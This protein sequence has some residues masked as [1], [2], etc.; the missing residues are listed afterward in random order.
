ME[1]SQYE[2]L[3]ARVKL[4]HVKGAELGYFYNREVLQPLGLKKD[5]YEG[6]EF[7]EI[8]NKI[9]FDDTE[10]TIK[11]INFKLE[12]ELWDMSHGYGINTLSPTEPTDFNVTINV[13]VD[14]V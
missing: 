2:R 4:I 12:T 1:K 7:L 6:A 13:F 3:F 5:T 14:N 10:Y 11:N 8:G 9:Q